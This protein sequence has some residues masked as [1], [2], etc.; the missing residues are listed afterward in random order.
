VAAELERAAMLC[1]ELGHT[2]EECQLDLGVSFD[3]FMLA[4]TRVWCASIAFW[5]GGLEMI[6][7]SKAGPDTL[8]ATTLACM[9]LGRTLSA[10][11]MLVVDDILNRVNRSVGNFFCDWDVVLSPTLP[12]PPAPHGT[13]NANAPDV[14]GLAWTTY[15]FNVSPFTPVFNTTGL[16]AI[17]LPLGWSEAEGLPL[18]MQFGARF[19]AEDTLLQLAG[20]LERAAPWNQGK[21]PPT[22]EKA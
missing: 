11:D 10:A 15:I 7:G 13:H 3:E 8:E 4:N 1:R 21:K 5:I 18:G 17:S 20:Q 9:E 12:E 6:T 22:I 2:V 16:P 14:D 19:G